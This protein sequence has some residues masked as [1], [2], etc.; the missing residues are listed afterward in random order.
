[1]NH[2]HTNDKIYPKNVALY[3]G[4][5]TFQ[6]LFT[7]SLMHPLEKWRDANFTFQKKINWKH[8]YKGFAITPFYIPVTWMYMTCFEIFRPWNKRLNIANDKT[9]I[10]GCGAGLLATICTEVIKTP[11]DNYVRDKRLSLNQ[12]ILRLRWSGYG[13]TVA[14]FA[15]SFSIFFGLNDMMNAYGFQYSAPFIAGAITGGLTNP[16]ALWRLRS[17]ITTQTQ[18]ESMSLLKKYIWKGIHVQSLMSGL[19]FGTMMTCYRFV[20]NM[21]DVTPLSTQS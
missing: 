16:I 4:G 1:M 13:R 15:P 9:F 8:A 14:G 20:R 18:V 7:R 21:S 17:Q 3:Y 19:G 6:S 12:P 11:L 5:L 10:G 2:L